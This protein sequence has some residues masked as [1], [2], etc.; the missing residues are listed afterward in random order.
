MIVDDLCGVVRT[1]VVDID[2]ITVECLAEAVICG[3]MF[4]N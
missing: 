2:G 4:V 1:T 3:E